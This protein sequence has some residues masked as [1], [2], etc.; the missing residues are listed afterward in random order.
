LPSIEL[1][2][3]IFISLS[4]L[5]CASKLDSLTRILTIVVRPQ[6]P[7]LPS[8]SNSGLTPI[9]VFGDEAGAKDAFDTLGPELRDCDLSIG[10]DRV[11]QHLGM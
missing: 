3:F 9:P 5:K 4:V 11:V 6:R 1:L 2:F 10:V 8:L 7:I